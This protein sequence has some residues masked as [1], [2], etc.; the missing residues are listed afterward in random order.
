MDEKLKLL[1]ADDD[2]F[3]RLLYEKGISTEFFDLRMVGN[4]SAALKLYKAWNPDI[5]VLDIV[6]PVMTGYETLKHI[7]EIEPARK[8][9][10]KRVP[11]KKHTVIIMATALGN[12]E[13]VMDCLKLGIDGYVVKPIKHREIS[14]RI[15]EYYQKAC[16]PPE[17]E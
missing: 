7:R 15:I 3:T 6:M 16:P 9:G 1:I 12:K 4:G 11:N 2:K 13:D 5:V 17:D 10:Q 14:S 8:K